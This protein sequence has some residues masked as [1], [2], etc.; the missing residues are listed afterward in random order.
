MNNILAIDTGFN[1]LSLA[2]RCEDKNSSNHSDTH[3]YKHDK[4]LL[5]VGHKHSEFILPK[6]DELLLRNNIEVKDLNI[7]LYNQGPG[8]FTGL[9]IGLS[10]AIGLAVALGINLVPIPSFMFYALLAKSFGNFEEVYVAIDAKMEQVY[11]ASIKVANLQYGYPP[12]LLTFDELNSI[13]NLSMEQIAFIG[14]GF[15]IYNKSIQNKKGFLISN[16]D[17]PSP[18]NMFTLFDSGIFKEVSPIEANLLY[19][20]NKVALNIEEQHQLKLS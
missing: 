1:Y 5:E 7:I 14:S 6:I 3:S 12:K 10:V 8:S 16:Y 20:R 19:L 15:A 2:L 17:Y 13:I 11:F 9:R 18:L 4:I